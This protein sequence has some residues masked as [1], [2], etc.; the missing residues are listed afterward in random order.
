MAYTFKDLQRDSQ[1]EFKE[2]IDELEIKLNYT[3]KIVKHNTI[4]REIMYWKTQI[5]ENEEINKVRWFL[6]RYLLG[7]QKD[8]ANF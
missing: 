7:G 2:W 8:N 6:E 5:L 1:D 4:K 3:K